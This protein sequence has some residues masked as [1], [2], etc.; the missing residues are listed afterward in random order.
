MLF[1]STGAKVTG[2]LSVTS[3]ANVGNLGTSGLINATGNITG[4]N[5]D[6]G[7]VLSVTGNANICNVGTTGVYATTLSASANANVGNLGTA[8]TVTATGNVKTDAQLV[9]TVATSTA[10]LVVT[11]TTKVANLYVDRA[12][13]GDTVT[14]AAQTTGN[15][16][17]GM[18]SATSGNLAGAANGVFVAN[19]ANGAITATTFVGNLSGN[20]TGNIS[21]NTTSDRKS[22]RLNSSH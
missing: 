12:A 21:G 4:G 20:I 3:N 6:T 15:Y 18:Y 22:T 13:V 17:L 19:I 2:T 14:V 9:S 5:I 8:G 7:G 16:Y 11:S 10:P 1:R